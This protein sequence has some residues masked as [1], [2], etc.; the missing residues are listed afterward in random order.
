MLCGLRA[1]L[2][3]TGVENIVDYKCM[4]AICVYVCMYVCMYANV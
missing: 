1:F 2:E 3:M 4:C